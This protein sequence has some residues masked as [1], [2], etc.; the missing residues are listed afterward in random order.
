MNDR[1]LTPE[2]IAGATPT[3]PTCQ[4]ML[5]ARRADRRFNNNYV[6]CLNGHVYIVV[7]LQQDAGGQEAIEPIN[8]QIRGA[9][10]EEIVT[11][12][13]QGIAIS[14]RGDAP[15]VFLRLGPGVEGGRL[16]LRAGE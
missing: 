8:E 6:E 14:F 2:Q 11:D 12:G 4:A 13:D 16:E 3:C 5:I 15:D 9:V 1:P 10:L 7:A